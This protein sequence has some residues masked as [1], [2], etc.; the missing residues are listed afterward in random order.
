MLSSPND[1]KSLMFPVAKYTKL[2]IIKHA[3]RNSAKLVYTL[4]FSI[5]LPFCST[6]TS[7]RQ[8][9][10]LAESYIFKEVKIKP[11][12]K[13]IGILVKSLERTHAPPKSHHVCFQRFTAIKR[14]VRA[15]FSP[16]CQTAKHVKFLTPF[17]TI[18][19]IYIV[20]G[21]A[22]FVAQYYC[23]NF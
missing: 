17:I 4:K 15:Q 16:N 14:G 22:V 23:Y 3:Y 7:K 10:C 6:C 5:H 11:K 9:L 20:S 13:D 2:L 18:I 1:V 12:Q 8:S 19:V 21:L